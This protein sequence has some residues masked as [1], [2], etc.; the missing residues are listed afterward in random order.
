[1]RNVTLTFQFPDNTTD[2]E[3]H[4]EIARLNIIAKVFS[5][6]NARRLTFPEEILLKTAEN[7]LREHPLWDKREPTYLNVE[8][9]ADDCGNYTIENLPETEPHEP[10]N[11]PFHV[12]L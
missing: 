12:A 9:I 6:Y 1:M 5:K 7:M 11:I 10:F 2:A 4:L 8:K 3:I